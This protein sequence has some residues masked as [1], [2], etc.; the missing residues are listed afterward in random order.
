[1]PHFLNTKQAFDHII[2]GK[3]KILYQ[4][5]IEPRENDR[6]EERKKKQMVK[7]PLIKFPVLYEL[8]YFMKSSRL[9]N[10]KYQQM[11]RAETVLQNCLN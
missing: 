11:K 7:N 1:M 8:K 10:A 5:T 3:V 9:E 6:Q 2:D 4:S